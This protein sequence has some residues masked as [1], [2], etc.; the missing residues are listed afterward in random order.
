MTPTFTPQQTRA[1][2]VVANGLARERPGRVVDVV[3]R[4]VGV[5]AQ[6]VRAARLQVR[7]RSVGLTG[8][9]VDA[10]VSER[11]VVATWAMRGTLHLLA[12]DDVRWIV[13]LLGPRFAARSAGRRKQ[14]GLDDE[15]CT[16]GLAA[17][18]DVLGASGPMVRAD[19][20]AAVAARGVRLDPKSQAPAHLLSYAAMQGLLC[21]GP[22][23]P[24]GEPT[25]VLLDAWVA[26]GE[27]LDEQSA[28]V[29]LAHR[30]LAGFGPAAAEDFAA[31]SGL[32]LGVA[33]QAFDSLDVPK[34][35]VGAS[36]APNATFGAR[37]GVEATRAEAGPSV[38]LLG[39]FDTYLLG[40]RSRELAVPPEF[41]RQIQTG[42]GFIMPAVL[43]DGRVVGTWRQQQRAGRIEVNV[44]PFTALAKRVLPGL[45]REVSD[46]G[47][48]LETDAEL[49][50]DDVSPRPG[51]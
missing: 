31:W 39:H 48:F 47:R 36:N 42:G 14:L 25:Y 23:W 19:L 7:A 22:A 29:R 45:R 27:P 44:Q 9:D 26:A 11:A 6:D 18:Q 41:D 43:V 5:Q 50:L 35:A 33:R 20:V 13:R 8:A 51:K 38:R 49:V 32:P 4:V 46:L 17:L 10:A 24:G 30:Y 40:Y 34:V 2:R 12:A 3:R 1:A 37:G 21:R 15:V 16:K 28:A